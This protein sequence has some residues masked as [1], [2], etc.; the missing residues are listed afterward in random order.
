MCGRLSP[1]GTVSCRDLGWGRVP[2][3]AAVRTPGPEAAASVTP[4]FPLC[5]L[6]PEGQARSAQSGVSGGGGGAAGTCLGLAPGWEG[7]PPYPG[8]FLPTLPRL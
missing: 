4:V 2:G 3:R 6:D 8:V 1:E 7:L 5:L